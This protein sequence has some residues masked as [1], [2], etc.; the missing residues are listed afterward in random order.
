M[1]Y[2][3]K[4]QRELELV[5]RPQTPQDQQNVMNQAGFSYRMTIGEL[6]YALVVARV[7]ISFAVIKLSQYGAN[8]AS[9][10]Y[11]AVKSVFAF[12]NNTHP[13]GWTSVLEKDTK[14]RP[15]TSCIAGSE[16]KYY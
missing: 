2:N 5:T 7:D 6:I 12:L 9:I 14:G 4:Y 13:G 15:T 8:P 16:I 3:S 1:K 10:H 11:Q